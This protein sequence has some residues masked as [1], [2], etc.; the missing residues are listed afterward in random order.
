M[1]ALTASWRHWCERR[2]GVDGGSRCEE[3]DFGFALLAQPPPRTV[4]GPTG[5][6]GQP[7]NGNE[8]RLTPTAF[9]LCPANG[10]CVSGYDRYYD[11]LEPDTSDTV[12]GPFHNKKT[13][14]KRC[15]AF[16]RSL[17]QRTLPRTD[18]FYEDRTQTTWTSRAASCKKSSKKDFSGGRSMEDLTAF[19][20][21]KLWSST[22]DRQYNT[23]LSLRM[24]FH[25]SRRD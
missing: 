21:G 19:A 14:T 4:S 15:S 13:T 12:S 22:Q 9:S 23:L 17:R 7:N 16:S 20:P 25:L 2:E 5:T 3:A 24:M 1:T 6:L 10:I 8:G 18:D 11:F